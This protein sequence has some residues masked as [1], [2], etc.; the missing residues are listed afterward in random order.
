M[1]T[2]RAPRAI[3]RSTGSRRLGA[4]VGRGC[5]R[6]QATKLVARLIELEAEEAD[7]DEDED[8]EDE[9]DEDDE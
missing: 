3:H 6:A 4:C 9:D 5:G 7:D 8:D 1:W 2:R